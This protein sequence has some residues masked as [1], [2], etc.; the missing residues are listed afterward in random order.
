MPGAKISIA[1]YASPLGELVIAV[2]NNSI[3]ALDFADLR[4]IKGDVVA[5]PLLNA[6]TEALDRYFAGDLHAFNALPIATHGTPFR[7]SVWTA[8]RRIPP[9]A[10]R[11][12]GDVATAIKRPSAVRAVGNAI[13]ANPIAIIVPCHRVIGASKSSGGYAGGIERK[14]WLLKHERTASGELARTESF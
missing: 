9:A 14:K 3:V 6:A 13:G 11:T 1:K 12:Y 5:D 7:E 4:E 10:T 8:L 2:S